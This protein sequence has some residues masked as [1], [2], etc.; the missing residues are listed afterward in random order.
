MDRLDRLLEGLV[1]ANT[2]DEDRSIYLFIST[3][4]CRGAEMEEYLIRDPVR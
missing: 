2:S 3:V 1:Y 4:L